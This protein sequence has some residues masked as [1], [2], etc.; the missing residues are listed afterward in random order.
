MVIEP[1][2]VLVN[3]QVTFS[4]ALTLTVKIPV[5]LSPE[6]AVVSSSQ[7]ML[8]STQ[9]A[10]TVSAAVYAPGWT[11]CVIV[12]LLVEIVPAGDPVKVNVP[13]PPTITFLIVIDP[14]FVLVNVQVTSSPAL[15]LN[16]AIAEFLSPVLSVSSP[17]TLVIAHTAGPASAAATV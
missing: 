12:P 6:L 3:V 16:V 2:C 4:P 5:F 10:G 15:T 11:A 14:L 7:L 13:V 1:F 17:P 8:V 9:P